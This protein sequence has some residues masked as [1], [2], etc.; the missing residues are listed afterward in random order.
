MSTYWSILEK[1]RGSTLRLTKLDDEIYDHLVADFP[2]FDPAATINEDEM[3]SAT[4]K[5]RWRNFMMKYEKRVDDFNFGTLLRSSPKTEYGN[6]ET[7]FGMWAGIFFRGIRLTYLEQ[8]HACSFT[9]SR[10]PGRSS[11]RLPMLGTQ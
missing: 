6:E 10:S 1:V 8:F 3:K 11:S 4:G 9:L 2:E 5:E 7:I